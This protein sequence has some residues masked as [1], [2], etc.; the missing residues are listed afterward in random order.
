MKKEKSILENLVT[1]FNKTSYWVSRVDKDV[2][3]TP[4]EAEYAK[5]HEDEVR[6]AFEEAAKKRGSRYRFIPY[7]GVK[8]DTIELVLEA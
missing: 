7:F 2:E 3:V 5:E 1:K 6:L 8:D 4:E